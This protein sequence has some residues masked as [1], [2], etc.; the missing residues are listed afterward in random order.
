[1][2]KKAYVGVDNIAR[3]VKNGYVGV[4]T[5]FPIY[6]TQTTTETVNIEGSNIGLYFK[7]SFDYFAWIGSQFKS[8]NGGVGGS[9]AQAILTALQDCTVTYTYNYG[10]E[11]NYD[12]FTLTV[13]GTIIHNNVSGAGTARTRTDTLTKGQKIVFKYTKDKSVDSNGDYIAFYNMSATVTTTKEVQVGTDYKNVARKILKAYIGDVYGRALQ[14]FGKSKLSCNFIG[15]TMGHMSSNRVEGESYLENLT[16]ADSGFTVYSYRFTESLRGGYIR[17]SGQ[18]WD[19]F[20]NT[21]DNAILLTYGNSVAISQ[22]SLSIVPNSINKSGSWLISLPDDRDIDGIHI[23]VNV[24]TGGQHTIEYIPAGGGSQV[25]ITD[26]GK[27]LT[28]HAQYDGLL[29]YKGYM[30]ATGGKDRNVIPE[31]IYI[32]ADG[33]TSD[34][35][36]TSKQRYSIVNRGLAGA[37]DY[38]VLYGGV[39]SGTYYSVVEKIHL[40]SGTSTD[41]GG[42][43]STNNIPAASITFANYAIFHEGYTAPDS[44]SS[45]I[46]VFNSDITKTDLLSSSLNAYNLADAVLGNKVFLFGTSSTTDM[47]LEHHQ[48]M[49]SISED[50]TIQDYTA[51][52]CMDNMLAASVGSNVA[53]VGGGY[54]GNNVDSS[55]VYGNQTFMISSGGTVSEIFD[56]FMGHSESDVQLK[57]CVPY[58][59]VAIWA[60]NRQLVVIDD[61]GTSY[62]AL[63]TTH[64]ING[65]TSRITVDDE[66]ILFTVTPDINANNDGLQNIYIIEQDEGE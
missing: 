29:H 56:I 59:N 36:T 57:T 66:E 62:E 18:V 52:S 39:D 16:W 46:S 23:N 50:L 44:Y 33:Q 8:N 15:T 43:A 38:A 53:I 28:P 61:I 22:G 19:S 47:P 42:I 64:N 48:N 40:P 17:I 49:I 41:L 3:K 12:K 20:N 25:T 63:T 35:A 5:A 10:T 54:N 51:F 13:N 65:M 1:M 60:K 7:T 21:C 9:T 2:A 14:I 26:G 30:V 11:A 58:Q 27:Y 45:N 24:A 31:R 4:R 34:Q 37:G 6:E 55:Y 32:I